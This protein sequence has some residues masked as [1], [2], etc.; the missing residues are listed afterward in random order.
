M[1]ISLSLFD[2]TL[3]VHITHILLDH[4]SHKICIG[5]IIHFRHCCLACFGV[6]DFLSN[7]ILT[8][9][10]SISCFSSFPISFS[11]SL[12]S[13]PI[14]QIRLVSSA[15]FINSEAGTSPYS[16]RCHLTK[17]SQATIWPSSR[18]KE[19]TSPTFASL[20]L[21]NYNWPNRYASLA[22]L[23]HRHLGRASR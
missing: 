5:S 16:G 8:Y 11:C 13:F 2:S 7:L 23:F 6:F 22:F 12:T 10:I 21:P 17:A 1:N 3:K 18:S 20:R 15:T 9:S 14:S 19:R 4:F